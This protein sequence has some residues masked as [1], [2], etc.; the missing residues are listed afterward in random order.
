MFHL[1]FSLGLYLLSLLIAF[2]LRHFWRRRKGRGFAI[3]YDRLP[4]GLALVLLASAA[5][6]LASGNED[7]A[8]DFAIVAYY[9][10][11]LGVV[12]QTITH[13]RG[14]RVQRKVSKGQQGPEEL[15]QDRASH[16]DTKAE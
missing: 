12:L 10:L 1:A 5:G 16:G 13:I 11:V 3:P 9:L 6:I 7:I 2:L 15:N 14:Q 4:I 8:N